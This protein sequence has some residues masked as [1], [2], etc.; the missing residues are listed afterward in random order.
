MSYNPRGKGYGYSAGYGFGQSSSSGY[1]SSSS[2]SSSFSSSSSSSSATG[3]GRESVTT[4]TQTPNSSSSETHTVAV[5]DPTFTSADSAAV[6]NNAAAGTQIYDADASENRMDDLRGGPTKVDV[7][8]VYS[9]DKDS[10]AYFNIDSS[11]GVVTVK[12][13]FVPGVTHIPST[14]TI[15]ATD[16]TH[17]NSGKIYS[18]SKVVTLD[19]TKVDYEV[20]HTANGDVTHIYDLAKHPVEIHQSAM[21]G[22]IEQGQ[23]DKAFAY[24]YFPRLTEVKP[25]LAH[26]VL[27]LFENNADK[28]SFTAVFEDKDAINPSAHLYEDEGKSSA[29]ELFK[30]LSKDGSSLDFIGLS[31][32]WKGYLVAY[33]KDQL[34]Q[35]SAFVYKVDAW[36]N[37]SDYWHIDQADASEVHL[38]DVVHNVTDLSASDFL[39]VK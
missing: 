7:K 28:I 10:Q 19:I 30:A 25:G 4:T 36:E 35:D 2:S 17:Y 3:T 21:V 34:G 6:V 16:P 1:G 18:A 13:G 39:V 27:D 32:G 22:G 37:K 9:L 15:T 26:G 12:E 23:L 8:L 29:S 14:I 24:E 38:V 20:H 33:G 11:T 5:Y 31:A